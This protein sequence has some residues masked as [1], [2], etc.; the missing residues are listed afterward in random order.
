MGCQ[1]GKKL[2]KLDVC[3]WRAGG[4]S[5]SL[6]RSPFWRSKKKKF[7]LFFLDYPTHGQS[8]ADV[9]RPTLGTQSFP[10]PPRCGMPK[11]QKCI[12]VGYD[13]ILSNPYFRISLACMLVL[14]EHSY[15]RHIVGWL[16][17]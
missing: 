7:V 1:K 17:W 12:S 9:D 15:C 16:S 3:F 14:T 4:F 6:V 8:Q 2:E 10:P 11:I 13:I 5:W